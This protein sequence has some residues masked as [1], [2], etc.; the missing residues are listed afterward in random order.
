MLVFFSKLDDAVAVGVEIDV[1]TVFVSDEKGVWF[2]LFVGFDEVVLAD[3][4][5]AED[6]FA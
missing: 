3:S 6:Q 2:P 1:R 5:V 4:P